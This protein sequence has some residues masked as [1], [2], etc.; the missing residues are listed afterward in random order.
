MPAM[1]EWFPS[2]P[3]TNSEVEYITF[4]CGGAPIDEPANMQGFIRMNSE[5]FMRYEPLNWAV[6]GFGKG[7]AELFD[8]QLTHGAAAFRKGAL[9]YAGVVA[10]ITPLREMPRND[11][12]MQQLIQTEDYQFTWMLHEKIHDEAGSFLSFMDSVKPALQTEADSKLHQLATIGAGL[13]HYMI[14]DE[15]LRY[16]EVQS[17]NEAF[18]E[19]A[20]MEGLFSRFGDQEPEA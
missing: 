1:T 14:S 18:P 17:M 15:I 6:H 8:V 7:S 2:R 19:L 13:M 3:M 11:E 5:P 9:L 10:S 16:S 12:A 4:L 20:D